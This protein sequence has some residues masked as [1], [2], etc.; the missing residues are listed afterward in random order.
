M[1]VA[2][3]AADGALIVIAV[4]LLAPGRGTR[5]LPAGGAVSAV[6]GLGAAAVAVA[7]LT[8][9][10]TGDDPVTAAALVP[11]LLTVT[12]LVGALLVLSLTVRGARA[13]SRCSSSCRGWSPAS[14]W[15]PWRTPSP[16]APATAARC[17]AARG[18]CSCWRSPA[19]R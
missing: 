12:A 1:D 17:R 15:S 6:V 2:V 4:A 7:A 11:P 5:W 10:V 3:G 14:S 18:P 16:S 19:G 13:G 9:A 8:P